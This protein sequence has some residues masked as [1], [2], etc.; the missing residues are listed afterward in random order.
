MKKNYCG[1]YCAAAVLWFVTAVFGFAQSNF[2]RGE[3]LFMQNKPKE[4]APFLENSIAD[5][6]AHVMAYLYLGMVYEQLERI[7]EAIAAYR[8][9]LDRAGDLSANVANNLGNAYFRKGDAAAAERFYTQALAADPGY[10]SACLGRAN[11]RLK[12]GSA[13][14]ALGDYE[15]YLSLELRSPK[16]PQIERLIAFIHS[17]SAA[18]E[19]RKLLAEEA[20]RVREE[21][22]KAEA[23]RRQR[24]LDEVSASL[25]SAAGSSQGLSSGTEDVER[26]ESEFELE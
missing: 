15:L 14:A 25:H 8:K 3:A 17:E 23:E 9:I 13:K 21:A 10:A 26:Y 4:A 11:A 18:E 22:A 2:T 24:L 16:R 12:A 6:P 1:K 5:D 19:R 7:D 20:A